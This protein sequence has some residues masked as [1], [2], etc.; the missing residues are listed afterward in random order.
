MSLH[1]SSLKFLHHYELSIA[2]TAKS[3]I[4]E[5]FLL[6]DQKIYHISGV[7][8]TKNRDYRAD[9]FQPKV[10]GLSFLF[11]CDIKNDC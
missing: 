10:L 7:P 3:I 1:E 5:V 9:S 2:S 4:V 6:G 8:I 11:C